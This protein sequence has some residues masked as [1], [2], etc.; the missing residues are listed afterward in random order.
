MIKYFHELTKEEFDK[1]LEKKMT[2]AVCAKLYPQPPWCEY[3]DAVC[4]MMGCWSLMG[5]H[6]INKDSCGNCDC[7]KIDA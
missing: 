5:F 2:W 3:T 4:G 7:I 6:I 1:L